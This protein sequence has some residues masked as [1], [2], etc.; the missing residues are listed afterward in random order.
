MRITDSLAFRAVNDLVHDLM[1]GLVPGA[2]LSLWLVRSA[3]EV[4]LDPQALATLVRGWSW[5][6]L[7]MFGAL[8]VLGVTG[9]IRTG[10]RGRNI[11]EHAM[12]VQSRSSAI[13]HVVFVTVF[14]TA[15]V[16]GFMV[17]AP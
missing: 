11:R 6:V 14:V 8:A 7:V 1:A 10:Y 12:G 3:A 15:T 4:S 9:V 2:V 5:L 16:T 13:K 17:I